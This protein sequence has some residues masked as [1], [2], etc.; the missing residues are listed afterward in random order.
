MFVPHKLLENQKFQIISVVKLKVQDM[1]AGSLCVAR[2]ERMKRNTV[3]TLFNMLENVATEINLSDTPGNIFNIDESVLRI[4][5]K[6]AAVKTG[7]GSKSVR[8]LTSAGKCESI[9][10]TARCDAARQFLPPV[11][12]CKSFKK[13][14][15]FGD[16]LYFLLL[17]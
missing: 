2:F 10:V 3:G 12:I 13:K 4:N 9:R 16:G 6:P 1:T 14:L 17:R 15:D 5:K 8:V 11:L 7:N